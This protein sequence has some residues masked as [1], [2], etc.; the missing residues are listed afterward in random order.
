MCN[1]TVLPML[2]GAMLIDDAFRRAMIGDTDAALNEYCIPLTPAQYDAVSRMVESFRSG[3]CDDAVA[4]VRGE[5]PVWPCSDFQLSSG[6]AE[7]V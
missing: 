4:R 7:A 1:P 5:C 6:S 3:R 2:L